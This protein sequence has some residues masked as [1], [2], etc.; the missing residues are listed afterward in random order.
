MFG[1]IKSRQK[2]QPV[3]SVPP[4]GPWF[5]FRDYPIWCMDY[6]IASE[7]QARAEFAVAN[8]MLEN[9]AWLPKKET[10]DAIARHVSRSDGIPQKAFGPAAYLYIV[11]SGSEG[12]IEKT[13]PAQDLDKI[14]ND[15]HGIILGKRW[16]PSDEVEEDDLDDIMEYK[17]GLFPK[18]MNDALR[19]FMLTARSISCNWDA[20]SILSRLYREM[21]A[22]LPKD[23]LAPVRRVV[24]RLFTRMAFRDT[25]I[26]LRW[27]IF[28][29][30]FS[31]L[32][33]FR[34]SLV[35]GQDELAF[36]AMLQPAP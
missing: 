2:E 17:E 15:L 1:F 29:Q 9:D 23:D 11:L 19:E 25:D 30:D 14:T 32:K 27:E 6:H 33:T 8:L 12:Y 18:N 36:R 26:V 5:L 35:D 22:M 13:N 28:A 20:A 4:I 34:R 3:P 7:R 21:S 24:L 16:A 31:M 10:I